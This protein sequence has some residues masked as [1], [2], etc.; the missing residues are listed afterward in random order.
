MVERRP[1]KPRVAGSNPVSR[2][3]TEKPEELNLE[4]RSGRSDMVFQEGLWEWEEDM[5]TEFY[6]TRR[7]ALE[8]G[9]EF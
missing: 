4:V 6:G 5:E 7:Q 1:S 3:M 8:D 2:S 9:K